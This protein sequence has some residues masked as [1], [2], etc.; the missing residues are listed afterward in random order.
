M[1][2][3]DVRHK[4]DIEVMTQEDLKEAAKGLPNSPG[5]YLM[6]D[7]LGNIIYVGKSKVLRQRVSS[8]FGNKNH[9]RH[10]VQRMV[11]AIKSFEYQVVDTELDALLLECQL[12]K[13]IRPIYNSLLKND[14]KYRYIKFDLEKNLVGAEVAYE[15]EEIGLYFGPY[16]MP[17]QLSTAVAAINEYYGLPSCK[18]I[19]YMEDCLIYR[20]GK[21]VGACE[22][23]NKAHYEKALQQ[24]IAF[25]Q[26]EEESILKYYEKNMLEASM[27]LEFE[28]ATKARDSLTVL[29]ILGLRKDAITL[30]L[31]GTPGIALL[32]LPEIGYKLY[33]L[34]GTKILKTYIFKQFIKGEVER[35]LEENKEVFINSAFQRRTHIEKEEIDEA[36]IMYYYLHTK[37]DVYYT[38]VEEQS[39]K[40]IINRLRE[41]AEEV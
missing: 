17:Y 1:Y 11:R 25:L 5:V 6:K 21:C 2:N 8:Y 10:K 16:D 30:S 32:K 13:K 28:A 20:L 9:D 3:I 34:I 15:K 12:I 37:P 19:L 35:L 23:R 26:G 24:A 31:E 14:K 7:A 40:A 41:W 27:A 33:L 38:Q 39:N 4:E 36:L 18:T 29:K 22:E